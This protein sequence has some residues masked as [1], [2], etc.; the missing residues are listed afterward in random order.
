MVVR[1]RATPISVNSSRASAVRGSPRFPLSSRTWARSLG[2]WSTARRNSTFTV[3]T[4]PRT[5]AGQLDEL[6]RLQRRH[7]PGPIIEAT[8]G[9]RV[10]FVVHNHLPEPTTVHWHGL[11]LPVEE[12]GVPGSDAECRS[13]RAKHIST[14]STCIRRERSSI[15]HTCRCRKPSGW[16][17]SLLFIPAVAWDPVVDRDFL[18]LFQNFRIDPNQDRSRFD[19]DG[20]ELARDQ[21]TQR[22]LYHAA[23]LQAWRAGADSDP[24]FQPHAA[25]SHPSSRPYLLEDRA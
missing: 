9:D 19:G 10:R 2:R 11:E 3:S 6:L 22:S 13:R 18:L 25:S 14:N 1:P 15:T 21:W 7:M 16:W 20:M 12:D 5:A 8:Q 17:G 23:G 24:R 4:S